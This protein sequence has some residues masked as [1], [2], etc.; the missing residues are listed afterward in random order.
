MNDPRHILS[1]TNTQI[2]ERLSIASLDLKR[3]KRSPSKNK[4]SL[5]AELDRRDKKVFRNFLT[6]RR[7]DIK[8]GR[9]DRKRPLKCDFFH[10]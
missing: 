3:E 8:S 10:G 2:L 6:Q 7:K 1:S 9:L 4:N 5:G